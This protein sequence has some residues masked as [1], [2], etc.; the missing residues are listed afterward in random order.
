LRIR[1]V[2]RVGRG[3]KVADVLVFGITQH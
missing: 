3:E 2:E 1:E